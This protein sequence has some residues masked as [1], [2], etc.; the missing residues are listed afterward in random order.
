[1]W[2]V[3]RVKLECGLSARWTDLI[4]MRREPRLNPALYRGPHSRGKHRQIRGRYKT[5]ILIEMDRNFRK[6]FN[7]ADKKDKINSGWVHI[8]YCSNNRKMYL[9][10]YKANNRTVYEVL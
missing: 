5:I 4:Y 9:R 3:E 6:K 2:T 1:M 10:A 7:F 8:S